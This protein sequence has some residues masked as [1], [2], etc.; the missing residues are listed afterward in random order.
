MFDLRDEYPPALRAG[1]VLDA[2]PAALR[3]WRLGYW[4][5]RASRE[6]E[7]DGL[8]RLV[9]VYYEL[10]YDRSLHGS[11]TELMKRRARALLVE[12]PGFEEQVA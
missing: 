10:A 7:L 9:D 3:L 5:G 6:D 1:N 4:D 11:F 12:V 2:N 8:R